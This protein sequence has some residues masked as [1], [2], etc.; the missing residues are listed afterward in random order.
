VSKGKRFK[1][2]CEI[3]TEDRDFTK[4][5]IE[6]ELEVFEYANPIEIRNTVIAEDEIR[7]R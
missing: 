6:K 3:I 1:L 7:D 2:S 5:D 4:E